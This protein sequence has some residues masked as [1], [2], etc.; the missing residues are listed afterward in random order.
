MLN[1]ILVDIY[2]HSRLYSCLNAEVQCLLMLTNNW[3]NGT[4]GNLKYSAVFDELFFN[5]KFGKFNIISK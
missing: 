2:S 4:K 3:N 5:Q 1:K